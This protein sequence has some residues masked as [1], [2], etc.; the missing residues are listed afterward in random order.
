MKPRPVISGC[1]GDDD[2]GVGAEFRL[3]QL[4]HVAIRAGEGGDRA[5]QVLVGAARVLVDPAVQVHDTPRGEVSPRVVDV[6]GVGVDRRLQR[7][8][9]GV[10]AGLGEGD[11]FQGHET[12]VVDG[13][14]A[15]A[16]DGDLAV[17][18]GDGQGQVGA[19]GRG[20]PD[21]HG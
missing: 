9:G 5:D 19:G 4:V 20:G 18:G 17:G 15:G 7:E 3:H 12:V 2:V 14:V 1:R 16:D 21:V 11:A 8:R 13:R 10:A 6:G